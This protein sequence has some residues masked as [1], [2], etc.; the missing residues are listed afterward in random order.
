MSDIPAPTSD[1]LNPESSPEALRPA[2]AAEFDR[3]AVF[4]IRNF[5]L[6]LIGRFI[7]SFG[8]QMLTVAIGWELYER[9]HSSLA[10][11]IVGLMQI[12]PLVLLTLPAG[13]YA[14][15]HERRGIILATEIAHRRR[16]RGT[17]ACFVVAGTGRVDLRFPAGSRRRALV[18]VAGQ[19][20]VSAADRAARTFRAG[21]HLEQRNLPGLGRARTG[22]RRRAHRR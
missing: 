19:R 18:P 4:R 14:D 12:L 20:R 22:A 5:R 7:A 16:M 13:H 1:P 2:R 15:N 17:D 10:L 9:T 21:R 3:Y 8:Q 11:G 6:Y